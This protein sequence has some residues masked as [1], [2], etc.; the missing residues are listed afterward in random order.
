MVALIRSLPGGFGGNTGAVEVVMKQLHHAAAAD[1][2]RVHVLC[3][4]SLY[5]RVTAA[6]AVPRVIGPP[7]AVV[8]PEPCTLDAELA[9]LDDVQRLAL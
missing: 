6:A 5:E 4:V 7:A 1:V 2:D 9:C 8:D 3:H